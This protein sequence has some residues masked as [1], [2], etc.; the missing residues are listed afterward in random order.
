MKWPD[1]EDP[2]SMGSLGHGKKLDCPLNEKESHQ[3]ALRQRSVRGR[4]LLA[5]VTAVL[6]HRNVFRNTVRQ[7]N[8]S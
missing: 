7:R 4:Q 8:I 3:K 6:S 2:D 5:I 1:S